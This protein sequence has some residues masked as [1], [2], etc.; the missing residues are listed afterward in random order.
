MNAR[1]L[2][3]PHYRSLNESLAD[4][5]DGVGYSVEYC[6][7][8]YSIYDTSCPVVPPDPELEPEEEE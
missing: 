8:G 6:H 1:C 5:E 4:E 2:T 7:L 3:C